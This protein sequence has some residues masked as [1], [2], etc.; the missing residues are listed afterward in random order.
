MLGSNS[1]EIKL[2]IFGNLYRLPTKYPVAVLNS[3][4]SIVEVPHIPMNPVNVTSNANELKEPIEHVSLKF[5]VVIMNHIKWYLPFFSDLVNGKG[6][7]LPGPKVSNCNR[8]N[9]SRS[10]IRVVVKTFA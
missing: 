2:A 8:R 6:V 1:S 5:V 9:T 7:R 4:K 3:S 10:S